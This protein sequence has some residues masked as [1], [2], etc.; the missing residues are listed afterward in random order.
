MVTLNFETSV[1]QWAAVRTVSE[2][3]RIPPQNGLVLFLLRVSTWTRL[4]CHG[5]S[6]LSEFS[7]PTIFPRTLFLTPHS[8]LYG[9]G[10]GVGYTFGGGGL[11]HPPIPV[12]HLT[13]V[14]QP[15]DVYRHVRDIITAHSVILIIIRIRLGS[16]TKKIPCL[17]EKKTLNFDLCN[18]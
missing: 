17:Y 15:W 13:Q 9:W 11:G 8:H 6:P 3:R 2:L 18:F 12:E 5:N 1:L 4:T 16:N 7:P 14:V 10:G